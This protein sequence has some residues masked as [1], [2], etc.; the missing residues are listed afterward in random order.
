LMA[1][2]PLIGI[3]TSLILFAVMQGNLWPLSFLFNTKIL[4]YLGKISY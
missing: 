2:Y 3:G 4:C 1:T